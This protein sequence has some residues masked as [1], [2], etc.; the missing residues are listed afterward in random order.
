MRFF[1]TYMP[2]MKYSDE[3]TTVQLSEIKGYP[4]INRAAVEEVHR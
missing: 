1:S 2:D 4:K 3:G